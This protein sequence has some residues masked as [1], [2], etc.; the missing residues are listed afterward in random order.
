MPLEPR[1]RVER[2]GLAGF[3]VAQ[4]VAVRDQG[5]DVESGL[6]PGALPLASVLQGG[7]WSAG[8]RLAAARRPGG[9]PPLVLVL[10]GAIF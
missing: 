3:D 1:R 4:D 10:D 8:R 5:P 2:H 7:T 6:D 9:E